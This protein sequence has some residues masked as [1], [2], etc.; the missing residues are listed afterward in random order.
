MAF[1]SGK[2]S[3]NEI[4]DAQ[5][6]VW[7]HIFK[8]MN[9]MSLNCAIELGIPDIIH[10]HGKPMTLD[11]LINAL[12]VNK[13]KSQCIYRLM[14]ILVNSEFFV[15]LNIADD[16]EK[17]AY[18][19]TTASRLLLKDEPMSM[20]SYL[21]VIA[22]PILM[23]PWHY[24]SEWLAND[25]HLTT[26]EIAHER[27]FWE[28]AK[29]VPRLNHAFNKSMAC[30]GHLMNNIFLKDSK[31]VFEGFESL[32]DVGGGTGATARAVVDAFP[33]M[34]CIVLDLPHVVDGLEGNEKLTYVGENMFE[35]IPHA[36]LV[37]LK[38][39]GGKVIIIDMIFDIYEGG[40]KAM[41]DQLFFDMAMMVYVNG[42]ERNEKEWAKL[43]SD[44]GF[45]GYNINAPGLGVRTGLN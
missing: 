26:F 3:S 14:R 6:H 16:K 25:N 39:K 18:W 13:A 22:D 5:S 42:K 21:Q 34:K 40:D 41:E 43:F 37:L 29:H 35:A 32:V 12:P 17:E 23:E 38:G 19:L 44:A 45:S 1:L 9:T 11:E 20:R 28:Q 24:L 15:K 2:V 4:L 33:D 31:Q 27:T 7:N 8:F 36:D 30:D 10:K